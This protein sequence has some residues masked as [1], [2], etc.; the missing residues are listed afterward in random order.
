MRID[1][2]PDS[3]WVYTAKSASKS[4]LALLT[5]IETL[6]QSPAGEAVVTVRPASLS[7]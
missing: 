4:S 6:S 1:C 3:E 2:F 7:H 5:G